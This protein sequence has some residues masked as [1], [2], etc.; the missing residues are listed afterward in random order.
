MIDFVKR[1]IG[2]EAR[3]TGDPG[4]TPARDVNLATCAIFLEMA[5]I[6]GEFDENEREHILSVFQQ[7]HDLSREDVLELKKASQEM[8]EES[9]D[10]WKFTNVINQHYSREEKIRIAELL[11]GLVYAD[12][13]MD[14]HENY[15]MHK[16]AKLLRLTHDDL[17]DAKLKVLHRRG[18]ST[19]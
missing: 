5:H 19:E 2:V 3:V 10:L 12:G 6:D 15:F 11:W 1:I 7:E 9:L 4:R 16:L 18:G 17:I 13:R 8:L 14:D